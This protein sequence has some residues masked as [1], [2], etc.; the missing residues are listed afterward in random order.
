M[1]LLFENYQDD[2]ELA[3][4]AERLDRFLRTRPNTMMKIESLVEA[5]LSPL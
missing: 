1:R 2:E 4:L 3:D 5:K